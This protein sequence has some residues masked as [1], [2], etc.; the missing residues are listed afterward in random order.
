MNYFHK[1]LGVARERPDWSVL[2][3]PEEM[4]PEAVLFGAHGGINGG[5]NLHPRL[6]VS[7]YEAAVAQNLPEIRRLHAE[8][9]RLAG[10]VY[11]VSPHRS[12]LICGL[13]CA[14]SLLGVCQDVPADPFR[15]FD[16]AQREEM[17]ARLKMLG[18]LG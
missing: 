5:A 13:K 9:M 17:R 6:Y 1:L 12:A 2:I 11:T 10:A 8:V 16:A 18:L 3:G 15:P 7:L 14:L 4:T